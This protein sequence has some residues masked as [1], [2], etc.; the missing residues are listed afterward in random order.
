MEKVSTSKEGLTFTPTYISHLSCR[1]PVEW[2][3]ERNLL[4]SSNSNL[5]QS[6]KF[7]QRFSNPWK[8]RA[9]DRAVVVRRSKSWRL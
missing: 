4:R 9:E 8:Q 7:V 5:I 1:F 2:R 6:S 3:G